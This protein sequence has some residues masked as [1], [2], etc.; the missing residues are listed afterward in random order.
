MSVGKGIHRVDARGKV[1]GTAD[2]TDDLCGKA[3]VAKV[4][5]ATIA[6]GKVLSIDTSEASKIKGVVKIL[7]CFEVPDIR[8]GTAGHPFV[9]EAGHKDVEDR[10]LL[11][12]R[13]RLYGDEIAAVVAVDE[14]A[15]KRAL[16]AIKVEYEEY[17]PILTSQQAMSD[18]A[19]Q[20]HEGYEK[21]ILKYS[22]QNEGDYDSAVKRDDL[23]I[24]EETVST[25][26][27]QHAHLE[28]STSFAYME[29]ERI[30]IVASTQIPHIMRRIVGQA[31]GLPWGRVRIIKP[32]LG[33]G[34]GNKQDI[35]YE[36]LNAYLSMILGGRKVKLELTREETFMCTRSRHAMEFKLKTGVDKDGRLVTRYI[37]IISSQGAYASHGHTVTGN[38]LTNYSQIYSQT[39]GFKGQA[40]T[41]YSNLGVG[42]AMRAYGVPQAAFASE[43]HMETIADKMGI[44]PI[45]FRMKNMMTSDYKMPGKDLQCHSTGLLECLQQGKKYIDW[46]K[47]RALYKNQTGILRRGVGCAIFCYKTGVYP[48]GLEI[49][50]CRMTLNQ[51]GSVQLQMGATEIGQGADTV[52][53]QMAAQAIGLH[54]SRVNIVSTQDTDVTPFDLGAFASRQTYIAG[55]AIKQTAGILRDKIFAYAEK[56]L[57]VP[58]EKMDLKDGDVI[59]KE[60]GELIADLTVLATDAFYSLENAMHLSAESTVNVKQ[61]T[62]SFGATFVEV[63]V[64]MEL[65]RVDIIDIIN[66]HDSGKI[67]NPAT[68]Q[69]QVHGGMHMSQGYAIMEQ[70]K[71]NE[72]GQLINGNFLDYKMPTAV[73]TP[74]WSNAFVDIDDPTGPFGNKSLGEPTTVAPAPAIRNAVFHATGV[75]FNSLPLDREKLALT[76]KKQ[77]KGDA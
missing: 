33:G 29:G 37:E 6:N 21:N 24:F 15:A 70:M 13:V 31:L 54:T 39:G 52:F 5:H 1:T 58:A 55:K 53:T 64:D 26:R 69:S 66:V 75:A 65:G 14:V 19:T 74:E 40:Y 12:E 59:N 27:V 73:D 45:E 68:A 42:G 61:N 67:I 17:E 23:T 34:F 77:L 51:D 60:N 28:N 32:Y 11:N 57:G 38:C 76:F 63:E 49:S 72:R 3:L 35:L 71:Y 30:V 47:K 22:E 16:K 43:V 8:F 56:M 18:K 36:P 62:F 41:V 44:D 25:Q 46:D 50:G 7:T 4:L 48:F 2:Y 10:K 9:L 20:L